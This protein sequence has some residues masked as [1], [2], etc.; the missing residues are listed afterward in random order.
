MGQHEHW[1]IFIEGEE[2]QWTFGDPRED[3]QQS[4]SIDRMYDGFINCLKFVSNKKRY[5]WDC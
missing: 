5:K 4:A 1:A 3:F 2:V